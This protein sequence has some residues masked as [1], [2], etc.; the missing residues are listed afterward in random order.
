MLTFNNIMA[1]ALIWLATLA[2]PAQGLQV[3]A[4]GCDGVE[5]CQASESSRGW[6]CG[7]GESSKSCCCQADIRDGNS[8]CCAKSRVSKEHACCGSCNSPS[9]SCQ[10]GTNCQC[11]KVKAPTPSTPPNEKTAAE[12]VTFDTVSVDSSKTFHPSQGSRRETPSV[13]AFAAMAALDR[14]ISLCRFTL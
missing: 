4:C 5:R 2:I 9:P 8:S 6:C 1:R 12:K 14:C 7:A 10:C 3:R 11:G 13:S